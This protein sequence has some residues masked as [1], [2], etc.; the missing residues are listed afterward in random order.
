MCSYQSSR[1]SFVSVKWIIMGEV[2]QVT[3]GIQRSS[4]SPF[5]PVS[6]EF[7]LTRASRA[8][9]AVPPSSWFCIPAP[10]V[11]PGQPGQPGQPRRCWQWEKINIFNLYQCG[12]PPGSTRVPEH[13][14]QTSTK[15]VARQQIIREKLLMPELLAGYF[16]FKRLGGIKLVPTALTLIS[17]QVVLS[18]ELWFLCGNAVRMLSWYVHSLFLISTWALT[19]KLRSP[20]DNDGD[21]DRARP[22]TTDYWP[23]LSTMMSGEAPP[24][25]ERVQSK[26][27]WLVLSCE[28][29]VI[30]AKVKSLS[31]PPSETWLKYANNR[32]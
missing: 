21:G 30:L 2:V 24:G 14:H 32:N 1:S 25:W 31:A 15:S 29:W 6:Q 23:P 5:S 4:W 18:D 3:L 13:K 28:L 19:R 11:P 22:L 12:G 26:T 27:V 20:S 9:T 7:P 16:Y 17:S 10:L 8:T